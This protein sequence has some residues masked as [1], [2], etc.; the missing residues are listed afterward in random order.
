MNLLN[1]FT[2]PARHRQAVTV[3]PPTV[4]RPRQQGIGLIELMV[5]MVIALFLLSGLFTLFYST[6]QTFSAQYHL[7]Q[8]Q[9]N[10]QLAMT[11]ITSVTQSAGYFPVA[12]PPT[13]NDIAT[14]A[15]PVNS[16]TGFTRAGQSVYGVGNTI[17][18]RYLT[19]SGDGVT[20]CQGASNTSGTNLLY[21]NVFSVDATTKTLRCQVVN[22]LT[23]ASIVSAQT[24]VDGIKSLQVLYGIGSAG[25]VTQY[26]PATAVSNWNN[27]LTLRITLTFYNPLVRPNSNPTSSQQ[28]TLPF[29][30]TIAI[31]NKS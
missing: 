13:G 17:S 19:A 1:L 20:N 16:A 29:T 2:T 30:R 24:L 28:A 26:V 18:I 27:V 23:G 7:A 31:M 15:L 22:G 4:V 3:Y 5:S 10:E 11:L 9:D 14:L 8:L 12:T 21:V 25:S 6:R